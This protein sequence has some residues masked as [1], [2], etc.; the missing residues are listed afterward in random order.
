MLVK[1][2]T[3]VLIGRKRDCSERISYSGMKS[4]TELGLAVV[5]ERKTAINQPCICFANLD[6]RCV[7]VTAG[8]APRFLLWGQSACE[9]CQAVQIQ[10]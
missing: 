7:I 10:T 6:S 2:P 1:I 9:C 3:N 5:G 8:P 4:W